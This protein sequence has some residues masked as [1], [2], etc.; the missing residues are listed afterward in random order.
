MM[1]DRGATNKISKKTYTFGIAAGVGALLGELLT[2]VLRTND[3]N[4][5]FWGNVM[6]IAFW[7]ALLG[8]GMS[9]G[10]LIAQNIYLKKK[11]DIASLIKT[12]LIGITI[13]AIAGG[14]AQIAFAFTSN[15]STPIEIISRIICW[16]ILGWGIG[17]GVSFFVP[18]YPKKR[19]MLAGALGGTIGGAVFRALFIIPEPFNRII[20][21]MILGV[22]IGLS[23]SFIEEALREAWL[24]IIW[25]RNETT[26]VSLGLNP[27]SF[28]SSR[29][30][31]VFLP[32]R[33]SEQNTPPIR[34]I[35][36]IENGKV[37]IDDRL[38]GI[39]QQLSHGSQ[40][41]L[42]SVRVMVNIKTG[43]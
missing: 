27:V 39:R 1:Q 25:G 32:R 31:D 21:V 12:A 38:T 11:P 9:A 10:L 34:A 20:G 16:G 24:T 8:F 14:L 28:G 4:G 22:F 26:T 42:G 36:M 43:N 37:V 19:A 41:D 33:P 13:G 17:F 6:H 23:I 15:I 35:F 30:A 7:A 2:D 5:T 3:G 29:E 40:V 18:N